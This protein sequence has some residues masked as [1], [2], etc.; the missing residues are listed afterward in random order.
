MIR[1]ILIDAERREGKTEGTSAMKYILNSNIGLRSWRLVPYAYY[2]H[3]YGYA[4]KLSKEAFVLLSSCDGKM[5]LEDS[6][7][8]FRYLDAGWIHP[9]E[10]GETMDAWSVPR[11]CD[12]RYFPKLNWAIT[13]KCNFNCRHCFM[14]SDNSP[15]L[16]EFS[17]EEWHKIL[18]EC[19]HC[20]IQS[21]TLTGGEPMLHPD[22]MEIVQECAR[23]R[24][25]IE[26]INTNGSFLTR[27]ILE[28]F[29]AL[30]IDTEFKISYDGLGHHDWLRG[31]EQ[32]EEKA[33]NAMRLAKEMGFRVRS[34]T[35]VH[36]K[37][38]DVMYDTVRL[39][40]EMGIDEIRIIRTT[41]TPRWRENSGD[42]TLGLLEYYDEM[43]KLVKRCVDS[44]FHIS[45]D[46]WQFL[47]YRPKEGTYF[48]HPVQSDCSRYRDSIPACRGTRGS[49]AL[50]FNGEIYPCNQM[51][52]TFA[53]M[54]ISFG[55]V[56]K[57]PLQ[58]LLQE[59]SYL[60][61]VTMPVSEIREANPV[62]QSCQY[63]KC[64]MGGC[65]A[66][67]VVVTGEYG[68]FDPA[69]CAFFKGGYMAK[70][71][72]IFEQAPRLYRCIS[73]TGNMDREGEPQAADQIRN[74]LGSY[75]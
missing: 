57:Q 1:R 23:R 10:P 42:A 24:L 62:C 37:N 68:H 66:I 44:D 45:V 56:K 75:A 40:D 3:G 15:M 59:G 73:E 71:D 8:L 13:G 9:A 46:V 55:N 18:D 61:Q 33:L 25:C 20:G 72:R 31:V 38:L 74:M 70:A 12:N 30:G 28:E 2:Y 54:G 65:R 4:Q 51:S 53:H 64:C 32:A 14:A 22:F 34:Q 7:L 47:H 5:E 16:G 48:F 6:P 41:E 27:E 11:I 26:E 43:L 49:I 52:G 67:A 39:L 63:W 36:R 29:R 17:R 19:E 35:N 21:I 50:S 58:Q 69:K 60:E